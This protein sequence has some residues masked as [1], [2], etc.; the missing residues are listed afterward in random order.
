MIS[1][2]V[3]VCVVALVFYAILP[4][5]SG[6]AF[7]W[8]RKSIFAALETGTWGSCAGINAGKILFAPAIPAVGTPEPPRELTPGVT[9]F[10]AFSRE[11]KPEEIP[12][13]RLRRLDVGTPLYRAGGVIPGNRAV[14]AILE[15]REGVSF[16]SLAAKAMTRP[17][18]DPLRYVWA[19]IGV[20]IEF[21]LFV[22]WISRADSPIPAIAALIA[23]FGK[24]LP[25]C[26]P[27]LIL[28]LWAHNLATRSRS[29]DKKKDRR[30][31]TA[32]QLLVALGVLANLVVVFFGIRQSGWL[33]P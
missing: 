27:G 20:F 11:G 5:A 25:W 23:I 6:T 10:I 19:A 3:L 32:G 1:S 28:T 33:V 9:V 26:P 12:S 15:Q 17:A 8:R 4:A 29:G 13:R 16:P 18:F 30:M 14:C 7:D 22:A 24:A 21:A 2:L 31:R